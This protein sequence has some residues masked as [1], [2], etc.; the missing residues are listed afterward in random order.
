MIHNRILL[1]S[2][3]VCVIA[4]T[5]DKPLWADSYVASKYSDRYH[6]ADCK[7]AKKIPKDDQMQFQSLDQI[8]TDQY[9]PCKK[10]IAGASSTNFS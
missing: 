9:A 7:I 4:F 10:C 5:F 2:L 6:K 3:L 1:M 8:P